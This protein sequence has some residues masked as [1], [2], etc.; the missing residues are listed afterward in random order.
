MILIPPTNR[1]LYRNIFRSYLLNEGKCTIYEANLLLLSFYCN[2]TNASAVSGI[3][4]E[5]FSRRVSAILCKKEWNIQ[6]YGRNKNQL[7]LTSFLENQFD[8]K[9]STP[10]GETACDFFD[11]QIGIIELNE[12]EPLAKEFFQKLSSIPIPEDPFFTTLAC[13][14]MFAKYTKLIDSH[15]IHQVNLVGKALEKQCPYTE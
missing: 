11:T 5:T 15:C 10:N 7:T 13:K 9:K 2:C 3:N 4:R 12:K 8:V 1:Y 6:K 14:M